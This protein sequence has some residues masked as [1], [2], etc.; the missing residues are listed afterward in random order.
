LAEVGRHYDSANDHVTPF[1]VHL[2]GKI[3][4]FAA[5]FRVAKTNGP[6]AACAGWRNHVIEM[7]GDAL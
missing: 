6:L 4:Q 7:T 2:A 3:G 5:L 1:I